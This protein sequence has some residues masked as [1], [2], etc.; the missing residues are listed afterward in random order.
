MKALWVILGLAPL[1]LPAQQN[2]APFPE[3]A[4]RR[5]DYAIGSWQSK[6]E[7]LGRQGEVI[8]TTVSE[9]ERRFVIEDRVVEISGVMEATGRTFRAWEYYDVQN[10]KYVL[11]SIDRDGRLI[12][13]SGEL[14]KEF[15]WTSEPRGLPDGSSF[16]MRNTHFD[17]EATSFTALGEISRDGGKTWRAFVRQFLTRRDE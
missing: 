9:D 1:L 17:V 12:T 7:T 14:G 15:R 5:L 13:M 6:T 4:R 10:Q 11:T 2:D 8:R 16:L 3:E